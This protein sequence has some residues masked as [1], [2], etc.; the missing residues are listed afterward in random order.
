MMNMTECIY[1]K[2][3]KISIQFFAEDDNNFSSDDS[4]SYDNYSS[5]DSEFSSEENPDNVLEEIDED[6][7]FETGEPMHSPKEAP[8]KRTILASLYDLVEV[9]AYAVALMVIVFLFVVKFVTVDGTSMLNTLKHEDRLVVYSLFYTPKTNDVIV[10]N[11]EDR[12]ELLVKRVIGVGGDVVKINFDTW[13]VW[14]ND[15]L[16][17]QSYLES[18]PSFKKVPMR[19]WNMKDLDEEN[20]VTFT[21]EEGKVFVMGDNRNASLDSRSIGQL[22]EDEILGKVILRVYPFESMGKIQ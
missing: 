3:Y 6:I 21:V 20:C 7:N 12:D 16:I 11:Y 5:S 18:N 15:E 22:D 14:V 19:N 9:F 2:T 10:I 1:K 8:P 4:V 13:D 17:D